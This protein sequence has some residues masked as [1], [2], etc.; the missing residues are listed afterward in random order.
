MI[1]LIVYGKVLLSW[2]PRVKQVTDFILYIL[3]EKM[4]YTSPS[5]PIASL[6]KFS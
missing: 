2:D 6:N 3:E 5:V 1:N 4:F